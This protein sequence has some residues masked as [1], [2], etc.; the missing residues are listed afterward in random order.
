MNNAIINMLH[1]VLS[2]GTDKLMVVRITI[3]QTVSF[4]TI[5]VWYIFAKLSI[6]N[7]PAIVYDG[8]QTK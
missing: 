1:A 6:D 8:L 5:L 7:A 4:V 2:T 3:A